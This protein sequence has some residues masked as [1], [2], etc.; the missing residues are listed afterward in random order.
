MTEAS[1]PRS[2]RPLALLALIVAAA[3]GFR[4]HSLGSDSIWFDERASIMSSTG[5]FGDWMNLPLDR[6][7]DPPD[8][9]SVRQQRSWLAAWRSP[10]FH[11][12]LFAMI[13][14]FWRESFGEADVT[15][16]SFSVLCSLAAIVF[17]YDLART[18]V[19]ES[20]ALW[21]CAIMATA[22]PQIEYAQEARGYALWSALTLAACAA[23]ARLAVCGPGWRRAIALTF[24]LIA[25]LLTHFLASASALALVIWCALYLRGPAL[26]QAL[27]AGAIGLAVLLLIGGALPL[28]AYRNHQDAMW[29]REPVAGH[30]AATFARAAL[31]PARFLTEPR[32]GAEP[33]AMLTAVVYL[34]P[35]ALMRRSPAMA[36]CA[37]L[38]WIGVGAVFV[39]DLRMGTQGLS[40]IRFTLASAP[41]CYLVIASL[42]LRKPLKDLLPLTAVVGCLMALLLDANGPWKGQWRELG[43]DLRGLARPGDIVVFADPTDAFLADPAKLYDGVGYY[44]RPIRFRAPYCF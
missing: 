20:P 22:P 14:R 8:F 33:I 23:A 3:A 26:R 35:L 18:L 29:L 36:L 24:C 13:L 42:P 30:I 39:A 21:A 40:Y 16:R 41:A 43:T 15:V 11:P 19:G 28:Q 27:I 25:M 34:L 10:D 4:L 1:N 17:L 31:I 9:W 37:L 38:L 6:L 5:H 7:I 32:A 12:P 2:W 44:S